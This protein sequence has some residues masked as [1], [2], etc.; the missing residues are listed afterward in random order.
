[1]GGREHLWSTDGTLVGTVRV[2]EVSG[3][4]QP[5]TAHQPAVVG[6]R[7][8]FTS[9]TEAAGQ[10]IWV[11]DGTAGG[12][13]LFADVRSGPEGSTPRHLTAAGQRLF[14]TAD[15][16]TTGQELWMADGTATGTRRAGDIA[17]GPGSAAPEDL[18]AAGGFLFFSA[19]DGTN[20]RDL[21]ALDTR[22]LFAHCVPAAGRLCLGDRRFAVTV[23][24]K[25]PL[26]GGTERS[27]TAI[28]DSDESGFFWFFAPGNLELVVKVLDGRALNGRFWVLFGALSDVAYTV[29]VT[30]HATGAVRTYP[31]PAGTLC[32]QA[33]TA[34]FAD[35]AG[36]TAPARFVPFDPAPAATDAADPAGPCAPG[37][38]RLCLG[39]GRFRVE[40]RWKDQHSGGREGTATAVP[41]TGESGSFW[42][43]SPGNTELVV[44]VLDG[45]PRNG[46][47]W[48]FYG[49]LSDVEY[50]LTVT[51]TLT[52]AAKTYHNPPGSYCGRGDTEGL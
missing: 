30:D 16:G 31:N 50:W 19:V 17:P 12:T 13:H 32:G 39:G 26:S 45:T 20:G 52:G 14:F 25:D 5:R 42:F 47:F 37:P 33:D 29:T 36:A 6:G 1:V 2:Q 4:D 11:S 40:A 22:Q 34:A 8:Y 10:E 49:A 15:D 21:W 44:K 28:P 38:S 43:F 27:G 24:F 23:R 18:T 41:R 35:P 9:W 51:D 46:K 48:I 7:L 3:L